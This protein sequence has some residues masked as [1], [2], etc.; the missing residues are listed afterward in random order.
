M[1]LVTVS[2]LG[3]CTHFMKTMHE[4]LHVRQRV[5]LVR[6]KNDVDISHHHITP[7]VARVQFDRGHFIEVD[8]CRFE[9]VARPETELVHTAEFSRVPNLTAMMASRRFE[10]MPPIDRDLVLHGDAQKASLYFDF[11]SGS[12]TAAVTKG[13]VHT[14]LTVN[15]PEV[16]LRAIPFAGR[17]LPPEIPPEQQLGDTTI[18]VMNEDVVDPTAPD[19]PAPSPSYAASRYD[20]LLHYLTAEWIPHDPPI[21]HSEDAAKLPELPFTWVGA[22]GSGCSNSNYP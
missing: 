6:A 17:Q 21:P 9:L 8:G 1:P 14:T 16:I 15:A 22:V 20:F 4:E 12:I 10:P 7:H 5:V 2:F 19:P 18:V 13:A 3:I 11:N